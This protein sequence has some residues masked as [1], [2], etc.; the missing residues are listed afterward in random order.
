MATPD[1]QAAWLTEVG[2]AA[3]RT[4]LLLGGQAARAGISCETCHRSGRTNPD[5][6]FPG[7]SGAPGTADVTSSLFSSHRGDGVDN[8]RPI[9]DL[10]GPRVLLKVSQAPQGRALET[11]IDGLVTQEFD[12]AEPPP[13]VLDGLAAYVRSLSPTACPREGV[14]PVTMEG[15]MEIARRAVIAAEGALQRRDPATAVLLIG[16]ARSALGRI[17]ER[18]SPSTLFA[19]R[20][21]VRAADLQLAAI[22]GHVRAS[23]ANARDELIVWRTDTNA[24]R[25]YLARYT[26]ESLFNGAVLAA[27][28]RQSAR[29]PGPRPPTPLA[30][31]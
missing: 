22:L 2:R 17:D 8:P 10:G 14:R 11:F 25:A 12:G 4:P 26:G 6:H 19:Q 9:P 5:F 27:V 15:E 3:F 18:F 1:P 31:P 23:E 30:T 29:T 21:R 13:A 7:V 16:A 28:L 24:L 20:A